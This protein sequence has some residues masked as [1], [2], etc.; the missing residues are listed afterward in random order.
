M[1]RL[2]LCTLMSTWLFVPANSRAQDESREKP[3]APGSSALMFQ[4]TSDIRLLGFNGGTISWKHHTSPAGAW[5]VGLTTSASTSSDD[6]D[7]T[8][9]NDTSQTSWLR[10]N[11]QGYLTFSI[12]IERLHY[13]NPDRSIS[14]YYGLGPSLAASRKT[15]T[16]A[17][18]RVPYGQAREIVTNSVG[19]GIGAA[20]GVECF[21]H[22]QIGI[23]GE[24]A[25]GLAYTWTKSE[26]TTDNTTGLDRSE[27]Q[28][29]NQFEL[30]T[31]AVRLG[32]SLYW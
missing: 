26:T 19:I 7:M 21:P 25:P 31:S 28:E 32:V 4:A 1:R 17:D 11:D 14:L 5:R 3:L 27:K 30:R 29:R 18:A 13:T 23:L 8:E 6:L 15:Q 10:E 16:L 24:Y 20:F 2:L 9:Y 12:A 22:R